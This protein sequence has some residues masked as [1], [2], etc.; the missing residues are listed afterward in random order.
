[1]S[2]QVV[3]ILRKK[4]SHL[5]VHVETNNASSSKSR[6]ILNKLVNLKSRD[7]NPDCDVWLSTPTMQIDRGKEAPTVSHLQN[8]LLQLEANNIYVINITANT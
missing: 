6:E 5:I 2:H 4:S 7:I 8:H 3:P 1:M